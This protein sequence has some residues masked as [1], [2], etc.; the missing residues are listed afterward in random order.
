MASAETLGCAAT[1]MVHGDFIFAA[2]SLARRAGPVQPPMLSTG[3]AL[4]DDCQAL[5]ASIYRRRFARTI[6]SSAARRGKH[7]D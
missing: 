3:S 5:K 2:R 1:G 6:R 7:D 4:R